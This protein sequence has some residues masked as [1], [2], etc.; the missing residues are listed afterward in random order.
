MHLLCILDLD[1]HYY[2]RFMQLCCV[3]SAYTPK[4]VG[5]NDLSFSQKLFDVLTKT[6]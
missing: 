4:H 3:V 2:C 5:Q 1:I 6:T